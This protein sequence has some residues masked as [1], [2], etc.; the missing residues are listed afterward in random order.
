V[1][2]FQSTPLFQKLWPKLLKSHALDAFAAAK[3][4]D[5]QK[6]STL[7]DAQAFLKDSMQAVVAKKTESQGGLVVT[8]RDSKTVTSYSARMGSMRSMGGMAGGMGGGMGA[9]SPDSSEEPVH[10]SAYKK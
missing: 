9:M 2:V 5:A 8:K 10:S 4:P 7:N 1:D 3:R 6:L